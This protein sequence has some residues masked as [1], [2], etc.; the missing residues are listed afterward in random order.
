KTVGDI[1]FATTRDG[2]GDARALWAADEQHADRVLGDMLASASAGTTERLGHLL[3]PAGGRYV[4]FLER[5]A[6]KSGP[7]GRGGAAVA[8]A[9]GRRAGPT[10]LGG[11]GNRAVDGNR[12]WVAVQQ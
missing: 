9:P 2:T 8:G 4:V 7:L 11:D 10:V 5:A 3:A 12:G 1:G 6:P